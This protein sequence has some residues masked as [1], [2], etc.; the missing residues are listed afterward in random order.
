MWCLCDP[1]NNLSLYGTLSLF[2]FGNVKMYFS[3]A[4][5]LSSVS[6]TTSQVKV[7]T[8]K[9]GQTATPVA[10]AT[11]LPPNVSA[12]FSAPQQFQVM[13]ASLLEM[14]RA[15]HSEHFQNVNIQYDSAFIMWFDRIVILDI[16]RQALVKVTSTVF[17]VCEWDSH[18]GLFSVS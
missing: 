14:W 18:F 11:Q 1:W 9:D 7:V 13:E 2:S 15:N 10:I 17:A 6:M 8:G 12:A 4:L 16:I 5:Y 3:L